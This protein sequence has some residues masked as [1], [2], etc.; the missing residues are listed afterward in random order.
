[1]SR[2]YALRGCHQYRGGLHF[3]TMKII[4]AGTPEFAVPTLQALIDSPH[5]VVAVYTQ[6]DRPAGRGRK[7]HASPVK[8]LAQVHQIPIHQPETL[9]D[10][11]AQGEL[12]ALHADVMVVV[13]Y[14]LLLPKAVLTLPKFGCIN[15]HG[16][17]LPRW[18]G[19]APIQRALEAGDKVTGITTMQMD[20]GLDTGDML[21]K[22][23]CNIAAA[24]TAQTVHDRLSVM[25]AELLIE[26][27]Q[28]LEAGNLQPIK[29]DDAQATYAAKLSKA[30][31]QI[32]WTQSAVEI[33]RRIHAFN[34]WPGAF[35]YCDD[36]LVKLWQAEAVEV[37]QQGMPGEIIETSAP[38]LEVVTGDGLVRLLQV[39]MAGGKKI[40]GS[41]FI[42]AHQHATA[43]QYVEKT[44][45]Q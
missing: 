17:L 34:P 28:A 44:H 31:A 45:D 42:N 18:R 26:T 32:D 14:G 29:Q 35:T 22:S 4:F 20:V 39:Q 19:A 41:D 16:S 1:M 7:I 2:Y 23:E 3:E 43:F 5:E 37:K 30:E 6:P 25:G 38:N 33:V 10:Q 12:A 27:L 8:Q 40:S 36:Q 24:D 9:R 13:A 11:V 21:L 15:V